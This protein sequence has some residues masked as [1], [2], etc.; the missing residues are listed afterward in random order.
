M[1]VFILCIIIGFSLTTIGIITCKNKNF[2]LLVSKPNKSNIASSEVYINCIGKYIV[3]LGVGIIIYG[4]HSVSNN[5][6][7]INIIMGV[8]SLIIISTSILKILKAKIN[9][10][11]K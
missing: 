7:I 1:T 2:N 10:L 3:F 6:I 5:Y 4:I 11:Y 8:S 9:M